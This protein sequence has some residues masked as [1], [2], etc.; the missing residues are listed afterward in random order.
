LALSQH[1]LLHDADDSAY[2][3]PECKTTFKET[4]T[5]KRHLLTHD[6]YRTV[7]ADLKHSINSVH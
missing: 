6:I 2:R 1:M 4:S 3:C 7:L 5:L